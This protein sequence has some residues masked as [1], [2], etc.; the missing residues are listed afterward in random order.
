MRIDG[1]PTI[2]VVLAAMGIM[3]LSLATQARGA[4]AQS[5]L[6]V[7]RKYADTIIEKGRDTYGPIHSGLI[8]SALDRT[9][10]QPLTTRPAAPAGVELSGRT[11]SV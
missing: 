3:S 9:T 5:Y 11:R 1:K 8:L 4:E 10:L 2:I 6:D 7:V